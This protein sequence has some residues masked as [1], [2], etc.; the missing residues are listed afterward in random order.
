MVFW[1]GYFYVFNTCIFFKN[2]RKP[3]KNYETINIDKI[4]SGKIIQSGIN[5]DY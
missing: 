3:D 5:K 1:N 2:L 4:N